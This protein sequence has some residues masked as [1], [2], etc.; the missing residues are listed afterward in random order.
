MP[1][2]L[3]L[4]G[5]G[6]GASTNIAGI[7]SLTNQI[8]IKF[9]MYS[10]LIN[11]LNGTTQTTGAFLEIDSDGL[12][13]GTGAKVEIFFTKPDALT[14]QMKF[15]IV[16]EGFISTPL[17]NVSAVPVNGTPL[18]CCCSYD[19]VGFAHE[20]SV[21]NASGT[22]LTDGTLTAQTLSGSN[23]NP[24]STVAGNGRVVLNACASAT[25]CPSTID[26]LAIY[27]TPLTGGA[28]FSKPAIGDAGLL[29][30]WKLDDSGSP[31]TAANSV[32]GGPGLVL[33]TGQFS[34]AVGGNWDPF[35]GFV[36][37]SG[38]S[39]PAFLGTV[40]TQGT[41]GPQT[42]GG[43][44]H[45]TGSVGVADSLTSNPSVQALSRL[46]VVMKFGV[47]AFNFAQFNAHGMFAIDD[48]TD[49][50]CKITGFIDN[51]GT[52]LWRLGMSIPNVGVFRTSTFTQTG[53]NALPQFGLGNDVIAYWWWDDAHVGGPTHGCTLFDTSGNVI[54]TVV[55]TSTRGGLP[56]ITANGRIRYNYSQDAVGATVDLDLDGAAI[57]SQQRPAGQEWK[58]PTINDAGIVTFHRFDEQTGTTTS[59][60]LG[61]LPLTLSGFSWEAGGLWLASS[62]VT[63][64]I[65]SSIVSGAFVANRAINP[66]DTSGYIVVA[67]VTPVVI[68]NA[69]ITSL[70]LVPVGGGVNHTVYIAG[71]SSAGAVNGP[72]FASGNG[73]VLTKGVTAPCF[74][75][76]G[77]LVKITQPPPAVSRPSLQSIVDLAVGFS[78]ANPGM[79]VL[80]NTAQ[81][82]ARMR[83]DQRAIYTKIA[84]RNRTYYLQTVGVTSNV[85]ASG[86]VVDLSAVTPPLERLLQL[87]LSDGRVVSL[88]DILDLESELAPRCYVLGQQLVE[89]GNDY[90]PD[91]SAINGTL[92][93]VAAPTDLDTTG[94]LTQAMSLPTDW[95][96]L[97]VIPLAQWLAAQDSTQAL[98]GGPPRDDEIARL[99]TMYEE[100]LETFLTYLD[101]YSGVPAL[102]FDVPRPLHGAR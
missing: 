94:D 63:I 77:T 21:F 61:G 69:P 90:S 58:T 2:V 64:P 53:P 54:G 27:S 95:S 62:T 45:F 31:S 51:D 82:I 98:Q 60:D 50:H 44:A 86:R 5:A 24:M 49:P 30:L 74:L 12:G 78:T 66:G 18:I 26:A 39:S 7:Q 23:L 19:G 56:I 57:Y 73:P 22:L 41:T 87:V 76:G 40:S 35:T 43:R 68:P 29:A 8:G 1:G 32:P 83:A 93:Y 9:Q 42:S 20:A 16:G 89:V 96:D 46:A 15:H 92:Y 34:W 11:F 99:Q 48:G 81:L 28:R 38:V 52:G 37:P 6:I 71:V 88:V 80:A 102:R 72:T 91:A 101:H 75:G 85:A 100:T 36:L 70:A 97:L 4:T 55:D 67:N 17:L 65:F 84:E 14:W 13:T 59:D 79:A 47:D 10:D 33:T 25:T 3:G